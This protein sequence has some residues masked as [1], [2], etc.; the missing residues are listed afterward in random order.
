MFDPYYKWLGILP[1]DQPPHHYR[2]LG[3]ELFE[4]DLD[5][6]EGAA[7]RQMGFVRQYQSGEHATHAAKILNELAIARLCLLKP[8]TKTAYDAKLRQALAPP[9]PEFPD[10]PLSTGEAVNERAPKKGKKKSAKSK[11]SGVPQPLMIGGGIAVVAVAILAV[12]LS[13][14]RPQREPNAELG[15]ALRDRE[16]ENPVDPKCGQEQC[17]ATEQ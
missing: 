9:E 1:K 11:A 15:R 12:F 7:D 16:R 5:V 14:G 6:I 2:L 13:S 10:L 3:V 17:D 4:G 8:A